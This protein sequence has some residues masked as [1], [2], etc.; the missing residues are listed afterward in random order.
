MQTNLHWQKADQWLPGDRLR[1]RKS[2]REKL[3]KGMRKLGVT[4]MVTSWTSVMVSWVC[5]C[6]QTY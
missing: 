2:L 4:E 1:V 6:V 3:Q 5:T